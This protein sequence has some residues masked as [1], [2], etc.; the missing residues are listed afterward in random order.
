MMNLKT[1]RAAGLIAR[2]FLS[3]L[4][5]LAFLATAMSA[6]GQTTGSGTLRGAIRDA[7]GAIIR[8]ATVSI[9]NERTKEQRKTVTNDDGTYVFTTVTPGEYTMQVEAPGFKKTEKN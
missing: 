7:Q 8:G 6:L 1:M 4:I 2:L 9:T 5:C 3:S